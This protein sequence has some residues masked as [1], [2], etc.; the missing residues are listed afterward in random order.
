MHHNLGR[1]LKSTLRCLKQPPQELAR[2]SPSYFSDLCLSQRCVYF[3]LDADGRDTHDVAYRRPWNVRQH[4]N[5]IYKIYTP[6]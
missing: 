6:E 2:L 5:I 4:D 3:T 1:T